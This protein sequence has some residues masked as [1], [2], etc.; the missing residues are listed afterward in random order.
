MPVAQEGPDRLGDSS[1]APSLTFPKLTV[2]ESRSHFDRLLGALDGQILTRS[3]MDAL[4]QFLQSSKNHPEA[5]NFQKFCRWLGPQKTTDD[6]LLALAELL[7]DKIHDSVLPPEQWDVIWRFLV[8]RGEG[9]RVQSVLGEA[10]DNI[11]SEHAMDRLLDHILAYTTDSP[12]KTHR[13]LG[14]LSESRFMSSLPRTHPLWHRIYTRLSLN[15]NLLSFAGHFKRLNG[16]KLAEALLHYWALRMADADKIPEMLDFGNEHIYHYASSP[17]KDIKLVIRDFYKLQANIAAKTFPGREARALVNLLV[18][19]QQHDFPCTLLAHELLQLL[20]A[21]RT[22]AF[23]WRVFSRM[24]G[25]TGLKVPARLAE[26]VIKWL[27]SSPTSIGRKELGR[28]WKTFVW[29][30]TVRLS[31]CPDLP[32][33]MIESGQGNPW[34]IFYMLNRQPV[35][36]TVSPDLRPR[37]RMTLFPSHI[38]TA[39]RIADAWSSSPYQNSTIAFRRTWEVYRFL[40]DRGAPISAVL[41]RAMVRA[42]ILRKMKERSGISVAQLAFVLDVVKRT[43]GEE[44]ARH[45][46]RLIQSILS[47]NPRLGAKHPSAEPLTTEN[48]MFMPRPMKKRWVKITARRNK[49]RPSVERSLD[50]WSDEQKVDA[51]LKDLAAFTEGHSMARKAI[52]SGLE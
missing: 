50:D 28:A 18:V 10:W 6:I 27:L 43:E 26:T 44:L 29:F 47:Q 38:D 25:R 39:H 48:T 23:V 13:I 5:A 14:V 32:L 20:M 52:G 49:F 9:D 40:Q 24:R 51:V 2:A 4:M 31:S 3:S 19:L 8:F 22:G 41:S 37:V 7:R 45:L 15:L 12:D 17:R 30:S 16:F 42:G 1:E 33:R 46:D 21:I 34:K 35:T 36:E 11:G